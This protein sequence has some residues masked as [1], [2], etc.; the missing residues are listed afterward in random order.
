MNQL[1][2]AH[3]S[4]Q[5]GVDKAIDLAESLNFN[6]IQ[7]FTKNNN[8]WSQRPF[9]QEEIDL[10]KDKWRNSNIKF[11]VAHDCYLI[12]LAAP[13]PVLYEK[14]VNAFI[15]EIERCHLLNVK[16][17]NF[18]PGAH[19][20]TGY[21]TGINKI[22]ESINIAHDKTSFSDVNTMLETTAGQGTSIGHSFVQ[23]AEIIEKVENKDRMS[24]CIDTAHILAAG[25]DIS[26]HDGFEKTIKE[27]DSILGLHQL[28]CFHVNDSKKTLNSRVDRHCN[29]GEGFIGL[30]GFKFLMNDKRLK[31]IPKILETPK[32][33]G[34]LED[35]DNLDRL[36]KLIKD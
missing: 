14:S 8:R 25:Y 20:G 31:A 19:L 30:E 4:I 10:F 36:K 23:L 1:L 33:K 27:F 5:G 35:L 34:Q 18:H 22:A 7:I 32:S 9:F 3:T 24:V 26:N 2:G 17:L 12:N 28:K 13:D 16:Y 29:I 15:D 6:A 21:E 11:I